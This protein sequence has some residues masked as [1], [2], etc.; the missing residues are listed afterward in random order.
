MLELYYIFFTKLCD[1]D[2]YEEMEVDTDSSYLALAEKELYDCI[3]SEKKQ[4]WEMLRSKDCNDSF[5]ADACSNICLRTCCAKHRKHDK[6]QPG[7]FKEEFRC[8]EKLRL[9]SKTHCSYDSEQ[10]V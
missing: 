5:T 4:E 7:L 1:T 8:T 9:C 6:R 10:Q 3:G 2:E